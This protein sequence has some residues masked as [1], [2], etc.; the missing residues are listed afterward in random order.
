MSV[1]EITNKSTA[2]QYLQPKSGK[3]PG[4]GE[5]QGF[6]DGISYG[7]TMAMQEIAPTFAEQELDPLQAVSGT[8]SA[9]EAQAYNA[10][11]VEKGYRAEETE[12]SRGEANGSL[13]KDDLQ[14]ADI[15][16]LEGSLTSGIIGFG[17]FEDG[18]NFSARYAER[19]TKE[20]PVVQVRIVSGSGTEIVVN[21]NVNEVDPENATELEM[22]AFLTHLDEQ[23]TSGNE[24]FMGSYQD[25]M[26]RVQNSTYGDV[27]AKNAQEFL[28]QRRDW[29][30][31]T[32]S[33]TD[34]GMS[35]A[36]ALTQAREKAA[37]GAPYSYLAKDGIIDYK[38]VIFVCDDKNRTLN[39]GDTSNPD[40]CLRIPLSGGGSLV[41]NRDNLGD[42]ARAIGMFSPEDVNRILRAIAEDAKVQQMKQQIDDETSGI[43]LVDSTQ[44]ADEENE[45]LME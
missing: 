44:E 13:E 32:L 19:S 18:T 8:A 30:N 36:Q 2:L 39:L 29:R 12:G 25:L 4:N 42:L 15:K 38:G 5:V 7:E 37:N 45:E 28:F 24:E 43:D 21:V 3:A 26:Y 9:A 23:G 14:N 11:M 10:Y 34:F 31:M 20:N 6:G 40:K 41:V 16:Q 33:M 22:F 1:T 17:S 35:A 27:S